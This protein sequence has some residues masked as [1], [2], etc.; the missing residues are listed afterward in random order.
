M[1]RAIR[2]EEKNMI[3]EIFIL[4]FFAL[5]KPLCSVKKN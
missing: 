3:T 5:K 2:Y 4:F 1:Q